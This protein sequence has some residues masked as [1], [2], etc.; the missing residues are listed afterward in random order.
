MFDYSGFLLNGYV[1]HRVPLYTRE[2][3]NRESSFYRWKQR[4][5]TT[6]FR[7]EGEEM[8]RGWHD[9]LTRLYWPNRDYPSKMTGRYKIRG[10]VCRKYFPPYKPFVTLTLL[11]SRHNPWL[12]SSY[13][14]RLHTFESTPKTRRVSKKI[15]VWPGHV[16]IWK[17]QRGL[18][19][20]DPRKRVPE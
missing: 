15:V 20:S 16:V 7:V 3:E 5:E 12:P 1:P 11:P 14:F 6:D 13:P 18:A 9:V 19:Y 8:G 2:R 10:S 4:K 17:P